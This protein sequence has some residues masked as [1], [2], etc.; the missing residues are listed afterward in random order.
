V[1]VSLA[2]IDD[3]GVHR[4][5]VLAKGHQAIGATRCRRLTWARP[6]TRPL[7]IRIEADRPN[8]GA[9]VAL[10]VAIS[11]DRSVVGN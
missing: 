5:T 9:V 7:Q 11:P 6:R 8:S 2:A 10:M 3:E 4:Y 1:P